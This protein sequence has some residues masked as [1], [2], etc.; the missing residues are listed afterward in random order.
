VANNVERIKDIKKINEESELYL[1]PM[2]FFDCKIKEIKIN[3]FIKIIKLN[4]TLEEIVER[5][6]IRIPHFPKYRITHAL[7]INKS[8]KISIL[9]IEVCMKLFKKGKICFCEFFRYDEKKQDIQFDGRALL[10]FSSFLPAESYQLKLI[11]RSSFLDYM[12]KQLTI[13]P[14]VHQKFSNFVTTLSEFR[15]SQMASD[16]KEE[17][18]KYCIC[19]EAM[20]LKDG[21][22]EGI[23]HK[24]AGRFAYLVS[25]EYSN[26]KEIFEFAKKLYALRSTYVHG[27]GRKIRDRIKVSSKEYLI[28]DFLSL[29]EDYVRKA[30]HEYFFL[31]TKFENS[32]KIIDYLDDLMLGK[33]PI[34]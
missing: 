26:R 23:S 12:H 32:E 21:D 19:L 4:K 16:Y 20:L 15:L 6:I 5:S 10:T 28:S 14:K 27:K 13:L 2:H 18:A 17:I 8:K 24:F 30:I 33:K 34:K 1:I 7:I 29:C 9:D 22:N 25:N 31:V 11:E 3:D